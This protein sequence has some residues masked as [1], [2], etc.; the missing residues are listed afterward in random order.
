[1]MYPEQAISFTGAS[2]KFYISNP[3]GVKMYGFTCYSSPEMKLK[4]W[5]GSVPE[6]EAYKDAEEV[7]QKTETWRV[8][9]PDG[10]RVIECQEDGTTGETNLTAITG[11]IIEKH[12][13]ELVNIT[14]CHTTTN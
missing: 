10:V 5:L 11:S 8:E 7:P 1:M 4:N 12:G 14:K 6:N 13:F 9:S 3:M 2:G